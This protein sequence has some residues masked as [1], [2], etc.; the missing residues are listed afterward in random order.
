MQC[1]GAKVMF[2]YAY[3]IRCLQKLHSEAFMGLNAV[4][5][6]DGLPPG[7]VYRSSLP[8]TPVS[9]PIRESWIFSEQ[10]LR[11]RLCK[12]PSPRKCRFFDP[13]RSESGLNSFD[14]EW[15]L[16]SARRKMETAMEDDKSDE[17]S[18][19][20]ADSVKENEAFYQKKLFVGNISYRVTKRQLRDFLGKFGKVVDC[21]IVQ[22]HI[23]RWPK[24]YGFVTFSKVEEAEKAR[25]T[26]PEQLELD[27]RQVPPAA[28]ASCSADKSPRKLP[29]RVYDT[30]K[31]PAYLYVHSEL[32]GDEEEDEEEEMEADVTPATPPPSPRRSLDHVDDLP[33]DALLMVLAW[34]DIKSRIRIERAL[35]VSILRSLLVRCGESLR[36]L[37]LPSASHALDYKAAEAI[38]MLCPNLE[39]LDASGVQLTNVSVQ[40]LAQKCPKLKTVLLSRC[41]DVGEKGLWWLLHL[42]KY[43]EHLD[44]TDMHKLSGQCFHMAGVRL[45]RLVL[46]GCSGVGASGFAKIATKC[47]FLSELT[48]TGCFQLTDSDLALLCQNLRALR[49][50]NLSGSFPNLIGDSIAAIGSLPLLEELNLSHNKAVVDAVIATICKGCTKLRCL[51]LTGC[52]AYVTDVVLGELARCY[53]LRQLKLNYLGSITDSGLGSLSCQGLLQHV[54]ARG[55][56]NVTDEVKCWQSLFIHSSVYYPAGVLILLELCRDLRLLDVSGCERVTNAAVDSAADI[57]SERPHVMTL[58]VG[59]TSVEPDDLYL[60][61]KVK[62]KID[63]SN[64]CVELYRPDRMERMSYPD[65]DEWDGDLDG[66]EG[67][68]EAEARAQDFLENDDPLFEEDYMMS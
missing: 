30:A 9:T 3:R 41:S 65:H 29:F 33:D 7:A 10:Q 62:L 42:C 35:T 15:L 13:R 53:G 17:T 22:D 21:T 57:V 14:H 63:R 26:P 45:R 68:G 37:D 47:C 34:L 12:T 67:D 11:D 38:S 8:A 52:S 23:K 54:E 6:P 16:E 2:S 66:Y 18:P 1:A 64:F 39:Y 61:P 46:C 36:S 25:N 50:L 43:L 59:G 40:Q 19:E 48:L 20:D 4:C 28:E 60:D 5:L 49:V 55:C 44:L 51:D 32:D 27:G 56:P 24:G 58:V 31:V